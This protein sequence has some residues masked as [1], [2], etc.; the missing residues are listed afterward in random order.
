MVD[1]GSYDTDKSELYV[2][3]YIRELGHLFSQEVTLL[4]LGVRRGGSLYLWRDLFPRAQIAGLDLNPVSLP[5]GS[6]RIHVYQGFQQ[7][8]VVL[9]RLAAEVAPEGFN[10]IVDDASH[11]GEYTRDSFWHLFRHHLKPGGVY[12]IDDWGCAYRNDWADGH[13]YTGSREA[14]GDFVSKSTLSDPSNVGRRERIRRSIRGAARPIAATI[15]LRLRSPLEKLYMQLDGA[16]I[17]NRFRSHD[18]G[19]AGI[20]KQ[21]VDAVAQSSIDRGTEGIAANGIGNINI[22]DS[23][24]FIHKAED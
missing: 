9:D 1:L 6:E 14:L 16:T 3:R 11:L 21:L 22:Y 15:P 8:P 10:I 13:R 12:V 4:E 17:Q 19:L 23:Q 7:D 24:V 5:D 18:Y 2:S 20:V